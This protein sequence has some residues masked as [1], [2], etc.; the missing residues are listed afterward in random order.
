MA[1]ADITGGRDLGSPTGLGLLLLVSASI[2]TGTLVTAAFG[3]PRTVGAL[4]SG[5]ALLALGLTF[6]GTVLALLA[7]LPEGQ[8]EGVDDSHRQGDR[9]RDGSEAVSR[10]ASG[11]KGRLA[12]VREEVDDPVFGAALVFVAIAV[13]GLLVAPD[14]ATAA[15][16][17]LETL[18]F[19]TGRALLLGSVLVFVLAAIVLAAGP[20]G[21]VRLGGEDATPAFST[22]AYVAMLFSAGIA[23]GVVFWGPA[24]ALLHYGTVPPFLDATA[25]SDAAVVGALQYTLFHWGVS[26]WSVYLAVGLPVA[27]AAYNRGAP[28]RVSSVLVPLF[29]AEIVERPLGRLVDLLAVLATL[30]GLSTTLGFLSTQFLTGIEYRWDVELGATAELLLVAGLTLILGVSVLTG[31]RRGMRRLAGL[32]TAVFLGLLGA[33]VVLGPIGFVATTGT[34]AVAGY[35]AAFVP[36]SLYGV[37]GG[38]DWLSTWTVFYWS[39]WLSWAPFVGLF[40]ARVSRGRRIRTVV[41]AAVGATSLM[42]L[43]WFVTVGSTTLSLQHSGA[44]DVL[45]VIDTAGVAAAGYPVFDAVS[46]GDLLLVAFLLLVITFFITSADAATRSLAMLTSRADAPSDSMRVALAA[47]VGV[48]AAV[49]IVVG[50][51]G[52]VRSAAVVVGGPFAVVALLA[53]AGLGRSLLRH[54]RPGGRTVT[55]RDSVESPEDDET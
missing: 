44:M 48:F 45:G 43:T 25:R 46:G 14:A 31:V 16:G 53:L 29:G 6:V 27:Y 19:E 8:S 54:E 39:W 3:L 22:P 18:V 10:V 23:A 32:N 37:A 12:A 41:L 2:V 47:L 55:G 4:I 28:L 49:L 24:E 38:G 13:G 17:A 9:G 20:W 1:V 7:A 15:V 50:G 51:R 35:A 21:R 26:A 34:E 30:G 11:W 36:M 5:R 42:T 52:T 33:L 40:I